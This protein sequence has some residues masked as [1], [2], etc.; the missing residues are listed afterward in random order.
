MKTQRELAVEALTFWVVCLSIFAI[1]ALALLGL[2]T[3]REIWMTR[4]R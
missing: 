2:W 4:R 1:V 3:L